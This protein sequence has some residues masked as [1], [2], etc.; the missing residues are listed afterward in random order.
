MRRLSAPRVAQAWSEPRSS[1]AF[2]RVSSMGFA[3]AAGCAVAP[4]SGK[5]SET[6]R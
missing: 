6:E 2:R 4:G 1:T 3:A 5:R